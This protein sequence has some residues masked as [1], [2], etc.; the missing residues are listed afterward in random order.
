MTS[1]E[2]V[3]IAMNGGIP[4][5]VPVFPVITDMHTTFHYGVP[6]WQTSV[7][8]RLKYDLLEMAV[9]EYGFDGFEAPMGPAADFGKFFVVKDEADKKYL[10]RGDEKLWEL[11]D[12]NYPAPVQTGELPLVRTADEVKRMA[13]L[14]AEDYRASGCL[15]ELERLRRRFGDDAYISGHAAGFTMNGLVSLRG[16]V[17]AMMDLYDDPDFVH[18]ILDFLTAQAIETGKAVISAGMDCIYIGD[19]WSSCSLISPDLFREFCLP[20]YRRAVKEF[21]ALGADVYLH[22]CGNSAPLF[23]MMA[24]TGVNAIEPLDPLGGVSVA[25]AKRRVGSRVC[26]KGG[27]NTLAFLNGTV[28]EIAAETRFCLE[29]GMRGGAFLLGSGDDLPRQSKP[30]NIRAMVETAHRYG[31]YGTESEE[32]RSRR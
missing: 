10:Y 8:P 25:D 28:E 24:D 17:Q 18:E 9:R 4:D 22:I 6:L 20:Y 1:R 3:K 23:E 14:K 29:Q 19:A 11:Y 7:F 15:D 32:E 30:E 2:R 27:V 13:F 21:R 26:L 5:R 31:K 12:D 16:S